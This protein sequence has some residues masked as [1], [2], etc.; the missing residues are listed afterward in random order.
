MRLIY[1]LFF[2]V[3]FSSFMQAPVLAEDQ[4]KDHLPKMKPFMGLVFPENTTE[5]ARILIQKCWDIDLAKKT[6]ADK[7]E[8]WDSMALTRMCLREEITK[9]WYELVDVERDNIESS[10]D[11]LQEGARNITSDAFLGYRGCEKLDCGYPFAGV[12]DYEVIRVFQ[13]ALVNLYWQKEAY[14][15]E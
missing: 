8:V 4:D 11:R 6:S 9:A 12:T 5:E 14:K 10:L 1:I 7:Y 13:R 15:T 2:A 3:V